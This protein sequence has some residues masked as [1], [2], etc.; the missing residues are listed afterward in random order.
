MT[1]DYRGRGTKKHTECRENKFSV[2]QTSAVRFFKAVLVVPQGFGGEVRI[3][4]EL[5]A[6]IAFIGGE[7]LCFAQACK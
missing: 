7:M 5:D 2:F 1:R 4:F 6:V 3:Q